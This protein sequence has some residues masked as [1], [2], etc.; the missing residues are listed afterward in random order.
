MY[1]ASLF[2]DRGENNAHRV[3]VFGI[4][5]LWVALAGFLPQYEQLSKEVFIL[6]NQLLRMA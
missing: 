4:F 6:L 3:L 2:I 1:L 5:I